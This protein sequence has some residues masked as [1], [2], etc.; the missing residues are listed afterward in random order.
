[1]ICLYKHQCASPS[2]Y[3]PS[4]ICGMMSFKHGMQPWSIVKWE[5]QS[6][7][8]T[9]NASHD[10]I[11]FCSNVANVTKKFCMDSVWGE[12]R[13]NFYCYISFYM[14]PLWFH[15]GK[16]SLCHQIF[17]EFTGLA[18]PERFYC[19]K[20]SEKRDKKRMMKCG[21]HASDN[22]TISRSISNYSSLKWKHACKTLKC[23]RQF[24]T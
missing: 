20:V 14:V 2:A 21:I 17:L 1:M 11:Q 13:N 5:I 4:M 10:D 8:E 19:A 22:S 18:N 24:R 9:T 7:C 3:G 15:W 6:A 16:A 23:F 12:W